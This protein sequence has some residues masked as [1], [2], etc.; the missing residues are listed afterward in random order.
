[1]ILA[2]KTAKRETGDEDAFGWQAKEFLRSKLITTPPRYVAFDNELNELPNANKLPAGMEGLPPRYF[3]NVVI[4][5]PMGNP[6]NNIDLAIL[7]VGEGYADLKEL[8]RDRLGRNEQ[9]RIIEAPTEDEIMATP[10]E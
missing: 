2:P 7:M 1:M 3:G 4:L 9:S 6:A 5:D 8:R 10:D